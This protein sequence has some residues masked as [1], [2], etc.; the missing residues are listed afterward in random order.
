MQEVWFPMKRGNCSTVPV[1]VINTTGHSITLGPRI[2][3]GHIESVKAVNPAA[4]QPVTPAQVNS[5]K[6]K[7]GE[8]DGRTQH[9]PPQTEGQC[10]IPL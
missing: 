4:I 7:P 10:G 2:S 1:S 6:V 9:V 3:L 5:V 8:T